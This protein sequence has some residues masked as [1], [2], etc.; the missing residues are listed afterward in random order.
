MAFETEILPAWVEPGFRVAVPKVNT[1]LPTIVP[2]LEITAAE[3][4][5]IRPATLPPVLIFKV[6]LFTDVEVAIK[7]LPR[8]VVVPPVVVRLL[9]VLFTFRAPP[10]TVKLLTCVDVLFSVRLPAETV[11]GPTIVPQLE[12]VVPF[13]TKPLTLPPVAIVRFPPCPISELLTLPEP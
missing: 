13:I 5:S 12:A 7:P 6:P 3:P 9:T 4:F 10:L 1:G 2:Q 11:T 8:I